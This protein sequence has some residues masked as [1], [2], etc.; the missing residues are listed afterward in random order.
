MTWCDR[1]PTLKELLADPII[2]AVMKAD[3]VDPYELETMLWQIAGQRTKGSERKSECRAM[4]TDG[5]APAVPIS[6]T[7]VPSGR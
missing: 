6:D 4:R 3:R 1:E 7:A 2:A 5:M